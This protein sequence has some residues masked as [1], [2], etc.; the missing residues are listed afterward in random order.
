MMRLELL[1][2]PLQSPSANRIRESGIEFRHQRSRVAD[3][4][5]QEGVGP[6]QQLSQLEIGLGVLCGLPQLEADH[7]QQSREIDM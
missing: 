1:S 4:F 5:I 2:E 3:R 7:D 6:F